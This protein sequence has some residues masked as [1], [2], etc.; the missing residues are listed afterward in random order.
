LLLSVKRRMAYTDVLSELRLTILA[1]NSA[2]RPDLIM[3]RR[4]ALSITLKSG[5]LE[6]IHPDSEWQI[7]TDYN[8]YH[9]P[10]STSFPDSSAYQTQPS[11]TYTVNYV[12][13]CL[14]A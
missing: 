12:E 7:R 6:K 5:L 9:P 4:T 13:E 10:L 2:M 11:L 14:A 3:P 1:I 8:R